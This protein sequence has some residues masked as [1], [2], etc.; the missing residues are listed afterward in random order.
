MEVKPSC[1]NTFFA[2]W[3]ELSLAC[4]YWNSMFS[5]SMVIFRTWDFSRNRFPCCY[6]YHGIKHVYE[7]G[8]LQGLIPCHTGYTA[9][10]EGLKFENIYIFSG[11]INHAG[12][13]KKAKGI[14]DPKVL[15]FN[16][17]MRICYSPS[18]S[19]NVCH[20]RNSNNTECVIS[21]INTTSDKWSRKGNYFHKHFF[22][23]RL[24][25]RQ[26]NK[27]KDNADICNFLFIFYWAI[28]KHY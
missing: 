5:K 6:T 23:I 12:I 18:Y 17:M 19:W 28:V 3:L 13:C 4:H 2:W 26:M 1:R 7:W 27:G 8:W 14:N 25:Q 9:K 15:F 21:E 20:G 10:G 22:G 16:I 24:T 11:S